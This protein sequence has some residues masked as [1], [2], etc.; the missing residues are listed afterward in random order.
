[1]RLIIYAPGVRVGGGRTLLEALLRDMPMPCVALLDERF[2]AAHPGLPSQIAVRTIGRHPFARLAC[3]RSLRNLA[4]DEDIVLCFAS[5]PPLLRCRG[6][7]FVYIQNR[8]LVENAPLAGLPLRMQMKIWLDRAWLRLRIGNA[9]GVIVQTASMARSVSRSLKVGALVMPFQPGADAAPPLTVTAQTSDGQTR[10]FLYVASAEPH[11]NHRRLVQA[12]QILAS[13]GLN[14]R[15]VLTLERAANPA[16]H[17]WICS[18]RDA[19]GLAIEFRAP[20]DREALTR[21]Y[22]SAD[23]L[24]F[25]SLLE[26]FGLPLLEAAGAGLPIIAAERDY[27]RDIVSPAESF[28]PCSEESIARAVRRFL[29]RPEPFAPIASPAQFLSRLAEL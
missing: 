26:S 21:L 20:C 24:I 19:H 1:M 17:D 4:T 6:R 14:P 11:K 28:D 13:D 25:P 5:L 3:E 23:A 12:W 9:R 8:Y 15:L 27:V 22:A 18:C 29:A 7:V 10:T 2:I 16:L